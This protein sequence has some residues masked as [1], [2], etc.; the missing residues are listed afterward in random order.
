MRVCAWCGRSG[1]V[2]ISTGVLVIGGVLAGFYGL[3]WSVAAS[4]FDEFEMGGEVRWML[5]FE[6]G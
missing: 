2:S 4:D 1:A 6:S 5:S 3:E